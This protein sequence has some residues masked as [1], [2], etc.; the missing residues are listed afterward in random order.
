MHGPGGK[1]QV[2]Y[3][4]CLGQCPFHHSLSHGS[5]ALN[6]SFSGPIPF[7]QTRTSQ[8]WITQYQIFLI[9]QFM[10]SP[11]Q[12]WITQ[13]CMWNPTDSNKTRIHWAKTPSS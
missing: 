7:T 12:A 9:L 6:F 1:K 11:F 4:N 5:A 3:T 10:E 2:S 8:A 13:L